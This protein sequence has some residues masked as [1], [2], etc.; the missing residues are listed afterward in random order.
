MHHHVTAD[1]NDPTTA[2]RELALGW[3]SFN[4]ATRLYFSRFLS[5]QPIW[6][7]DDHYSVHVVWHD[8][9]LINIYVLVVLRNFFPASISAFTDR[10]EIHG[11][12][13]HPAKIM[14]PLMRTDRDKIAAWQRVIPTGFTRGFY[15]VF[16]TK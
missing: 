2:P 13:R 11:C 15:P 4:F 10:G 9:K 14:F 16:L 3:T 7:T 5:R 8:H 12:I 1:L 6:T